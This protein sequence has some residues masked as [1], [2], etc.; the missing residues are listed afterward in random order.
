MKDKNTF[1]SEIK[2]QMSV[3]DDF[4][5]GEEKLLVCLSLG[6]T[7]EKLILKKVFSK[8]E[9]NKIE[10]VLKKRLKHEPLNKIFKN[11]NFYGRDFYINKNVL[12]PRPETEILV[13]KALEQINLL[14]ENGAKQI[15]VL[16]VCCGSGIIGLSIAIENSKT[17]VILSDI[18]RKALQV[19]KINAKN[20]SVKNVAILK[21]NMFSKLKESDRFDIIVSNPPYIK[22][23][24]LKT[25][26]RGVKDFDPN[27]ALDGGK[28]GL[29][30]YREIAVQADKFLKDN[31]KIFVEI[32]FDQRKEVQKIFEEN[33]FSAKTYKDYAGND[34]VVEIERKK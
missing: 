12:A 1:V 25:L 31:G 16:D 27:I 3:L 21:S 7:E 18:S 26:S 33:G 4:S 6:I 5:F 22:N 19:A 32:G 14:Q 17:Y 9:C 13:Q 2:K 8:Q 29:K 34:R 11:Q 20:L 24:K 10:K 30:F 28:D 23:E 15:D